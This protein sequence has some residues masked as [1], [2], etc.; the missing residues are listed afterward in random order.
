MLTLWY[1][2]TS[3]FTYDGDGL[4]TSKTANGKTWQYIYNSD[5]LVQMTDGMPQKRN[6]HYA[7][8]SAYFFGGETG[9]RTLETLPRLHD[10]QSCAF[11]QLSHL[12]IACYELFSQ[13]ASLSYQIVWKYARVFLKKSN[14]FCNEMQKEP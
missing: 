11:D 12:S 5:N 7:L 3:V 13:T 10:F 8:H 1:L 9:I 14:F 6:K 4:R 2:A